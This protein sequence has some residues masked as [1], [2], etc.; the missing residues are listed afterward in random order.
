[1]S[2]SPVLAGDLASRPQEHGADQTR[3]PEPTCTSEP[4][5]PTGC[6]QLH[7]MDQGG[8]VVP[9]SQGGL[10]TWALGQKGAPWLTWK[11][12]RLWQDGSGRRRQPPRALWLTTSRALGPRAFAHQA[13]H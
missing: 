2:Q 4:R 3:G 13:G 11:M 5:P 7:R 12:C 10:V 9:N 8:S 6:L 1:M